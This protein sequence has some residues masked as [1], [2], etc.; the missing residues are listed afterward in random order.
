MPWV[1]FTPE[2]G[3]WLE[4]CRGLHHWSLFCKGQKCGVSLGRDEPARAEAGGLSYQGRRAWKFLLKH[5][6][7]AGTALAACRK[8]LPRHYAAICRGLLEEGLLEEGK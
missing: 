3:K 1:R 4:C 7:D 8:L 2:R 6:G 5:C